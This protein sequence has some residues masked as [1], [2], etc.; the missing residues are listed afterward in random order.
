MDVLKKILSKA[1]EKKAL[2]NC[3]PFRFQGAGVDF[4]CKLIGVRDIPH[5][6]TD[7]GIPHEVLCFEH[8]LLAKDTAE[9][10]GE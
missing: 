4:K 7:N 6:S 9:N 3:D 8:M 2:T 10:S 1:H 5:F